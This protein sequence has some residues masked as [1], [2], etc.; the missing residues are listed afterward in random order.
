MIRKPRSDNL[1]PVFNRL[2]PGGH[3]N[4]SLTNVFKGNLESYRACRMHGLR[5]GPLFFVTKIAQRVP[6][7]FRKP[8]AGR[9]A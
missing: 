4:R 2:F 7:F 9:E 5:V 3:T 6:Q 1:T 8:Q